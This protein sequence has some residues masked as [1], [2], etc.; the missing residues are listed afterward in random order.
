MISM[1]RLS[2][3]VQIGK[4]TIGGGAPVAVQ[5]MAC[6]DTRD[7]RATVAQIKEL[8]EVDCELVRV[9]VPD[10]QAARAISEIKQGI[11]IPLIADIHFDYRLALLALEAVRRGK[12]IS[13]RVEG[14]IHLTGFLLLIAFLLAVTYQDIIRIVTGGSLLP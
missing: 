10:A 14:M 13:P 7:V 2:R 3:P 5:S 1:R 4:V 6:T 9:A 8:E 12:R 11:A